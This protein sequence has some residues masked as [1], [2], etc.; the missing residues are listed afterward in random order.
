[1][2]FPLRGLLGIALKGGKMWPI[3]RKT[4]HGSRGETEVRHEKTSGVRRS[5]PAHNSL[6]RGKIV[7]HRTRDFTELN[8]QYDYHGSVGKPW[9]ISRKA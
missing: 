2:I 8:A 7:A 6:V 5:S 9:S 4:E 1:M 3:S